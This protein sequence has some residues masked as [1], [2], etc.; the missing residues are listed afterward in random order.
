MNPYIFLFLFSVFISSISQILLKKSALKEHD[1][2]LKEYLNVI[3]IVAYVLFLASAL[4]TIMAYHSINL[5]LGVILESAGYVFV[6]VLSYFFLNERLN[7]KQL[8]GLALIIIGII[9]CNL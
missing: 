7:Y 3:V 5:S 6:A 8:C 1:S 9:I 2:F 4:I